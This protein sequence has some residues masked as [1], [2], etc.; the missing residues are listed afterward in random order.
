MA[1]GHSSSSLAS[2]HRGEPLQTR[3]AWAVARA[4][5]E[6]GVCLLD[7]D[8]RVLDLD[9]GFEQLTG[10]GSAGLGR[11]LPQVLVWSPAPDFE[12][13]VCARRRSYAGELELCVR[14]TV[15]LGPVRFTATVRRTRSPL[16]ADLER[17]L[18]IV[19]QT[20]DAMVEASPVTIL[21]L[22]RDKRVTLW[23]R[24]A[25]RMFGWSAEEIIG[26]PYPLV[27]AE[28]WSSFE[29]LYDQVLAG[30]G[31]T[32]VESRR[33][34]RDGSFIDLRMHTASMRNA[35]GEVTGAM[36]ILEDLTET[37]RLEER[38]RHAQKMEAVGR[39]AGGIAHDFNNLLT[40]IIGMCDLMNLEVE[41]DPPGHEYLDEIQRVS[42]SAR[43]LVAQ[44]M[45]FSRRQVMRP[46]V[47]DLNDRVR[48]SARMIQRLIRDDI[49]LHLELSFEPAW[50]RVDPTHFDQILV[51]LAV[52]ASDAMPAGGELI[53]RTKIED[54]DD[55]DFPLVRLEVIDTGVGIP[56]DVLPHI[57][58]PFFT[59]KAVGAGTGLGLANVY[60][61]VQQSGGTVEVESSPEEGA[62]FRVHLPLVGPPTETPVRR[63]RA[64]SIPAGNRESILLVEDN[65]GVRRST[66]K[67][68]RSLGYQVEV[69]CD[70]T[71]A[72]ERLWDGLRVDLV[73]TDLSMPRMGG[74]E[75]AK[76]LHSRHP[77][78]PIVFMSGNLDV[79]ELKA[80]VE[81]GRATFLQKPVSIRALATVTREIFARGLEPSSLM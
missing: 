60:G 58:D 36:A 81:A 6:V 61:I 45:T 46:Q 47:I 54:E 48:E 53:F 64:T 63:P 69:A 70:G 40:I 27:P 67:L 4:A 30:E 17:Q 22:D 32:G 24:A 75:L 2:D 19:R 74:T 7:G 26:Q 72:L 65:D 62:C 3:Y 31:F 29:K 76:H 28:E 11:R 44:L 59:T 25:E 12:K 38:V 18:R 49:D 52:N 78:L 14:P 37:R 10:L 71:E 35:E 79:A 16:E 15:A 39:L 33:Q 80:E 20:L 56:E 21:T 1:T 9:P 68:L 34:R 55:D 57:F 51:N 41:L 43:E 13:P 23:N 77:E 5:V 66:A 8:G 73:L 42:E 50:V